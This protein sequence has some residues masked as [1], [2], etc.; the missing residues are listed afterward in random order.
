MRRLHSEGENLVAQTDREKQVL[1]QTL[2]TAQ[3][4]AQQNLRRA[5]SDH[6]EEVQ[7]LLAEKVKI[8]GGSESN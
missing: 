2:S 1:T 8:F 6:Q 7:R 3:L 4:E 5:A